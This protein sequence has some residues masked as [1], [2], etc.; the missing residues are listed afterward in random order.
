MHATAFCQGW[1]DAGG[2]RTRYVD[3]GPSGADVPIVIMLHGTA[4]TWE[5]FCANIPAHAERYRCLALDMIG[6]GFSSKPD[7]D[8]EITDYVAHVHDFMRAMGVTRASFIGVSLG[9]WVACRLALDHPE[10]VD[11]LTL[12][13]ASGMRAN[14]ETMGQI[15]G[16]RTKAVEDPSWENVKPIFSN[17]MFDEKDR[18]DD[19]VALRQACYR[20]PEMKLAMQHILCLQEPEIRARNLIPVEQWCDIRAPTLVFAAPQDRVDFYETARKAAVLI[21]GARLV[22]IPNVKHWAQF[23]RPELFNKLNL[24]FLGSGLS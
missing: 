7:R 16:A 9:A 24:E 1:V 18:I 8:Y 5:T 2:V 23:E 17:L 22:E 6:S 3:A 11:K 10:L 14:T 12:V 13:A 4:S 20:Q 15:K 21:P 19:L